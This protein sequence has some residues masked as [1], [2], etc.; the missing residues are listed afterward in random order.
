MKLLSPDRAKIDANKCEKGASTYKLKSS[1]NS[2]LNSIRIL[3]L[4]TNFLKKDQ[5]PEQN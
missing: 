5:K 1:K 4:W 2:I 3:W